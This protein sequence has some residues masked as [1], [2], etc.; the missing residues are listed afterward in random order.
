MCAQLSVN[1]VVRRWLNWMRIMGFCNSMRRIDK[2]DRLGGN[3]GGVCGFNYS[4][5]PPH[6]FLAR[7]VNLSPLRG[8]GTVGRRGEKG[9]E[10]GLMTQWMEFLRLFLFERSCVVVNIGV[11]K[12][13]IPSTWLVSRLI[14]SAA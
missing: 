13:R 1:I 11:Y 4:G 7:L 10:M 3:G 9:W 12:Y 8:V 5:A 6:V 2:Q 14:S